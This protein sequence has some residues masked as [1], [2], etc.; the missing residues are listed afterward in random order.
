MTPRSWWSQFS[1]EFSSEVWHPVVG[2]MWLSQGNLGSICFQRTQETTEGVLFPQGGPSMLLPHQQTGEKDLAGGRMGAYFCY[3]FLLPCPQPRDR[4]SGVQQL[5]MPR[6]RAQ[7]F[8]LPES[9][10][11]GGALGR[12]WG[13][14]RAGPGLS[15]PGVFP[16]LFQGLLTSLLC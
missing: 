12:M 6:W 13:G 10:P 14:G 3:N 15:C 11:P 5:L 2:K 9:A 16:T 7:R 8:L 1:N 4:V